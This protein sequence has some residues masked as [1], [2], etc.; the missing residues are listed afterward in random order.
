[1]AKLV[2][3][4]KDIVVNR[5]V[6]VEESTDYGLDAVD[7]FV[8]EGW[9]ERRFG[10]VLDIGA[11]YDGS[12]F[13]RGNLAF[14]GVRMVP[15]EAESCNVVIHGEAAGLMSVIP[16]HVDAS[17]QITIPIFGDVVVFLEGIS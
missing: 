7:S 5:S 12:V 10:G 9:T 14:L 1:M 11:I 8:V 3:T 13:V 6:I 15:F 16:L 4:D 17:I 2:D